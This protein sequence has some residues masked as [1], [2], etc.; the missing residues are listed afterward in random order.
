MTSIAS[1]HNFGMPPVTEVVLSVQFEPLANFQIH[2][3]GL[4]WQTL[5]GRFPRVEAHP[6]VGRSLEQFGVP[7]Q[8]P[9][10]RF[11]LATGLEFPRAWFLS[12]A[13]TELIQLQRDRFI[14]NWRKVDGS[15]SYPRYEQVRQLFEAEY[16]NFAQFLVHANIDLPK[17]DQCEVTYINHIRALSADG[18]P[19]EPWQVTTLLSD[20][21]RVS[22]GVAIEVERLNARFLITTDADGASNEKP[23]GRLHVEFMP[24]LSN[25]DRTPIFV[26]SLVARG[27]PIS[28]DSDGV[29]KFLDLGRAMIVAKF[30]ELTTPRMHLL[31]DYK[32]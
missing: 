2:H 11:E 24:A 9:P 21:S 13:G 6:P 26:F 31:W 4:F 28:H 22:D 19:L 8:V 1:L 27:A 10:F 29:L 32:G 15:Q 17:P 23:V 20:L 18:Q 12:Q 7:Q 5:G 30:K 25:A 16:S 14:C 3:F